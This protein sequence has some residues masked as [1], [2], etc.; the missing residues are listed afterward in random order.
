MNADVE[1]LDNVNRQINAGLTEVTIAADVLN[2]ASAAAAE[3]AR[4]VCELNGAK[5]VRG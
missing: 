5:L 2:K 4:R 1:L 3:E